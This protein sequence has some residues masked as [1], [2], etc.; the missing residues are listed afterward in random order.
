MRIKRDVVCK[1][2]GW[3]PCGF[4]TNVTLPLFIISHPGPYT[5][6][7]IVISFNF[8]RYRYENAYNG[9]EITVSHN[10]MA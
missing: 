6:N 5:E 10:G 4:L 8:K 9:Q 1:V 3:E 2:P 7:W